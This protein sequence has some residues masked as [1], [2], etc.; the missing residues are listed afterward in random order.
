MAYFA[1]IMHHRKV[2][3]ASV[4]RRLPLL[5][6]QG[7]GTSFIDRVDTRLVEENGPRQGLLLEILVEVLI[8]HLRCNFI[9]VVTGGSKHSNIEA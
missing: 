3:G 5:Q 6:L 7:R 4:Q 9:A 1:G 2:I 8:R